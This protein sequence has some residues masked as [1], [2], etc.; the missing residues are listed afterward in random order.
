MTI[1]HL[2]IRSFLAKY[3]DII[4]D[5][6]MKQVNIM[7]FTETFLQPGQHL[8]SSHLP[9]T[10]QCTVFRQD[11]IQ[12]GTEDLAKGGIMIVCPS[13][14]QPVRMNV[15]HP[16]QLEILN[17][18]TISTHSGG[19]RMR[20]IAVYSYRCP[21][22]RLATFLSLVDAY[23]ANVPQIVPTIILGDFNERYSRS[24]SSRLL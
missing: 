19:C 24:N 18:E 10:D 12:T 4:R 14:L 5:Q 21:Q 23:L 6:A 20:I 7:C 3:E 9:M 22:Q 2:N 15:P 8:E 11:R 16:P 1:S 13:S 17:V